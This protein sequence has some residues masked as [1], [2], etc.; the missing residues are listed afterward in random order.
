MCRN[1][2]YYFT[3]SLIIFV[4]TYTHTHTII[5][6][7]LFNIFLSYIFYLQLN[8]LHDCLLKLSI[9]IKRGWGEY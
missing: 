8:K 5:F 9:K 4:H 6:V 7:R 3:Y 2:I 1:K